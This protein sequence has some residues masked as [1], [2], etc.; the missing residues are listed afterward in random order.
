MDT[1]RQKK[2]GRLLQK[3][4]GNYFQQETSNYLPGGL[5]TVTQVRTSPDLGQAKVYLSMFPSNQAQKSILTINENIKA[6]RFNLGKLVRHQLRIVP[7]LQF[8]ID[9][10]LDYA[11]KIEKLLND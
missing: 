10:S 3:E 9:D 4:L 2:V 8:F 1:V 6:I 7:E 5:I 11:D